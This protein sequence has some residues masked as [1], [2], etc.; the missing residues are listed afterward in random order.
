MDSL[1]AT[2]Y[3]RYHL[4]ANYPRRVFVRAAHGP[5][6]LAELG[7][8]PQVRAAFLRGGAR[9][10]SVEGCGIQGCGA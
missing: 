2:S 10:C 6:S 1:D 8:V 4:V 5:V 9:G 7:L 3:S